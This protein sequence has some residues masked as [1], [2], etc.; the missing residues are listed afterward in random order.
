MFTHYV[1]LD[2]MSYCFWVSYKSMKNRPERTLADP[3]PIL[4]RVCV[5][6]DTDVNLNVISIAVKIKAMIPWY[7]LEDK[8]IRW[9]GL[10][11]GQ[12]SYGTPL[13]GV[14]VDD[15]CISIDINVEVE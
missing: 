7:G 11:Q 2:F 1:Y 9:R 13:D 3:S 12:N 4:D 15:L 10:G 8:C 6:R 5:R 14:L